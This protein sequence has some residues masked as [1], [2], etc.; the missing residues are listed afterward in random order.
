M[1]KQL[2]QGGYAHPHTLN[3][4]LDSNFDLD[5]FMR[6]CKEDMRPFLKKFCSMHL[7]QR[8]VERDV[9]PKSMED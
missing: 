3:A 1:K 2:S 7:F 9:S 5:Y 4:N 8:F 6:D